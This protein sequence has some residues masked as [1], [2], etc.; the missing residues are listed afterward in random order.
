V[1]TPAPG[2]EQAASRSRAGQI[3]FIYWNALR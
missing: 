1:L 2:P 3:R